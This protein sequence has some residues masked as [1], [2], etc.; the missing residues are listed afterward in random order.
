MKNRKG[1]TLIELIATITILGIIMLVAI[2]NIMSVSIKSKNRSYLNDAN[3]LVSLAKY[4][5]ESDPNI[6]KPSSTYCLKIL[7][8]KLDQTELQKGPEGGTYDTSNS[9]VIVRYDVSSYKYQYYVQIKEN[10]GNNKTKGIKLT[11]YENVI[12]SNKK[13]DLITS[14]GSWNNGRSECSNYYEEKKV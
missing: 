2:P 11:E 3:K 10:Y 4:K 5:F 6:D 13:Q 8:G 7:L 9:Y 14:G 1:F 12:D